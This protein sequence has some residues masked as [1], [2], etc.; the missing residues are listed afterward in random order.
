MNYQEVTIISRTSGRTED[1]LLFVC[2]ECCG[3]EFLVYNVKKHT[4]LQCVQCGTTQCQGD[5]AGA[6]ELRIAGN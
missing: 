2:E 5:C 4:H 6:E 1:A 3:K